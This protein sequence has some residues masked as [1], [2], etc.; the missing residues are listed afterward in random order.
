VSLLAR[1]LLFTGSEDEYGESRQPTF[2]EF[3]YTLLMEAITEHSNNV[4][5][6]IFGLIID[7]TGRCEEID[8]EAFPQQAVWGKIGTRSLD[9]HKPCR[10]F[11]C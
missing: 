11:T 6:G 10:G 2:E 5:H 9:L 8:A 4:F 1:R 3:E 7:P